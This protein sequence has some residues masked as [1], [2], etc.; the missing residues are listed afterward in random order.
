MKLFQRKATPR[1]AR[2]GRC[3]ELLPDETS[4]FCQ[5]CGAPFSNVPPTE[6]FIST[7][8]RKF[9]L[10]N[11]KKFFQTVGLSTL[12][13]VVSFASIA[14]L[15][16]LAQRQATKALASSRKLV[17]Y[18]YDFKA[19]P[20]LASTYR[21]QAIALAIQAF[22]DHFGRRLE[23]YEIRENSLPP[24]MAE[25][26]SA[27]WSEDFENLS[28]WEEKMLVRF[29]RRLA[30]PLQADLP[31][32]VSN[33]P[34][35]AH[36]S[37]KKTSMETRHLS[38]AGLL[39]GLGSP[40]FVLV[41]TYRMLTDRKDLES[42]KPR[43]NSDFERARYLGEYLMAHEWG[44]ALLGLPDF[45]T[46]SAG[47]RA[48]A[49]VANND[50]C[51]M[52]TDEGGGRHAWDILRRRSLGVPATCAAYSSSLEIWRDRESAVELI[53]SGR[54]AEAE[55]L[56]Q[57]ALLASQDAA[58]P[59]VY[60]FLKDEHKNFLAPPARWW[61]RFFVFQSKDDRI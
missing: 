4:T 52:H 26:E 3:A 30:S 48:P 21:R 56:H 1:P 43:F 17:I 32:I 13:L 41:S 53:Q 36:R 7:A 38:P 15:E 34:L 39:S 25:F 27:A 57:K 44:H 55:A 9:E 18:T 5:A 8:E 58:N 12:L 19:F 37:G 47:L 31:V 11:R 46:K 16:D 24:E 35:W 29:A 59:W 2:C 20:S 33:F 49:S 23:N 22:E 50:D 60:E 28:F 54:R 40:A 14:L 10:E 6:N 42:S 61:S 51:L 45:V